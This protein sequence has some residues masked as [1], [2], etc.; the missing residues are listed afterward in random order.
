MLAECGDN[1]IVARL[2]V[3]FLTVNQFPHEMGRTAVDLLLQQIGFP[4]RNKINPS[5]NRNA[6]T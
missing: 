5:Q 4:E 2:A 6:S 1:H 3:P